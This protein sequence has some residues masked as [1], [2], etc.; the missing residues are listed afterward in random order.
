MVVAVPA[1]LTRPLPLIAYVTGGPRLL[2]PASRFTIGWEAAHSPGHCRR[3][4]AVHRA[5][6]LRW[7][8][9][10]RPAGRLGSPPGSAG[11]VVRLVAPGRA[12]AAAACTALACRR[13]CSGL[14]RL[15][16]SQS[17]R[18][19]PADIQQRG[20]RPVRCALASALFPLLLPGRYRG[21]AGGPWLTYPG[22]N[23]VACCAPQPRPRRGDRLPPSSSGCLNARPGFAVAAPWLVDTDTRPSANMLLGREASRCCSTPDRDLRGHPGQRSPAALS[24]RLAARR[25]RCPPWSCSSAACLHS[26]SSDGRARPHQIPRPAC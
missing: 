6:V 16:A 17:R 18:G 14:P 20:A 12:A 2:T 7:P 25:P 15:Y 10:S 8:S 4:R 24:S 1:V 11:P 23:V 13:P 19:V 21:P 26:P 9:A 3:L 22:P 5:D